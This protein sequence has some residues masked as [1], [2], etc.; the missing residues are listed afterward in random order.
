MQ[1]INIHEYNSVW[2][3]KLIIFILTVYQK[4]TLIIVGILTW[5]IIIFEVNVSGSKEIEP[6]L[7]SMS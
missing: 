2:V 6:N 5:W 4:V 3:H 1:D 7:Y